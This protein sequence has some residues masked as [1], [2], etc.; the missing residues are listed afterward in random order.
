MFQNR[1]VF[2]MGVVQSGLL[3]K[4]MLHILKVY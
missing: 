3:L 2:F 1:H 4:Q